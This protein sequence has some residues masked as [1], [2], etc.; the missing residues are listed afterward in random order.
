MEM[1]QGLSSS[2]PICTGHDRIRCGT[3]ITKY[4]LEAPTCISLSCGASSYGLGAVL[5]NVNKDYHHRP[6][7]FVSLTLT[8]TKRAYSQIDKKTLWHH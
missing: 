7:A 8:P 4:Y 3:C 6:T 2:I 5:S 1:D